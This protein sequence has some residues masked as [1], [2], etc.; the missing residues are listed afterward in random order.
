VVEHRSGGTSSSLMANLRCKTRD[1]SLSPVL[2]L[3][4]SRLPLKSLVSS[5]TT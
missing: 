1:E 5:L 2:D 3:A 4:V